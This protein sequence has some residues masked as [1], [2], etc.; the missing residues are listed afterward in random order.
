MAS[1][2]GDRALNGDPE[3]ILVHT[4]DISETMHMTFQGRSCNIYDSNGNH[5]RTLGPGKDEAEVLA[6]YKCYVMKA[7][8]KFEKKKQVT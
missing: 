5:V 1:K 2:A 4:F 8:V 7:E 3:D 6:G